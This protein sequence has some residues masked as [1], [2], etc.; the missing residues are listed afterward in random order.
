MEMGWSDSE[1]PSAKHAHPRVDDTGRVDDSVDDIH[2]IGLKQVTSK[3][4]LAR[5]MFR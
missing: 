2:C 4:E 1:L 3:Y 5:L